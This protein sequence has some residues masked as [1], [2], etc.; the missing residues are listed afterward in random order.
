MKN[1]V[2]KLNSYK[3]IDFNGFNCPNILKFMQ[4]AD[5]NTPLGVHDFGE[6]GFVNVIE[7][8]TKNVK[9]ENY[10]V[11]KEYYD[12]HCLLSG[13]EKIYYGDLSNMALFKE[14]NT[15]DEASLHKT[16]KETS[17]VTY[18]KGEGVAILNPVAHTCV[19]AVNEEMKI[20]KAIIKVKEK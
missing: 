1:K 18:K 17:F 11:H 14:Y 16:N 15:P 9:P 20:K 13:E 5:E 10:E 19:F 7:T 8:T 12:I 4:T 2:I 3:N 6:E